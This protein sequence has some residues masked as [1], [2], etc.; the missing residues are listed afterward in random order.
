MAT[1]AEKV[2]D[3]NEDAAGGNPAA[4]EMRRSKNDDPASSVTPA[5]SPA[6]RV[7]AYGGHFPSVPRRFRD[8]LGDFFA[9]SYVDAGGRVLTSLSYADAADHTSSSPRRIQRAAICFVELGILELVSDQP[10]EDRAHPRDPRGRFTKGHRAGSSTGKAHTYQIKIFVDDEVSVKRGRRIERAWSWELRGA[11]RRAR[12]VFAGLQ[13]FNLPK[14][15]AKYGHVITPDG[16]LEGW[17]WPSID[18]AHPRQR[19][20][21]ALP[22]RIGR[23]RSYCYEGIAEL[24]QRGVV[25]VAMF[26]VNGRRVRGWKMPSTSERRPL[27]RSPGLAKS[28]SNHGQTRTEPMDKGG[29]EVGGESS[30]NDSPP[31]DSP[32]TASN[33]DPASATPQAGAAGAGGPKSA[34]P[35]CAGARAGVVPPDVLEV[36][37]V[38]CALAGSIV[39]A[40]QLGHDRKT[41]TTVAAALRAVATAVPGDA[42]KKITAALRA[43]SRHPHFRNHFDVAYLLGRGLSRIDELLR[44]AAKLETEKIS[45]KSPTPAGVKPDKSPPASSSSSA[46]PSSRAPFVPFTLAV[47]RPNLE[48]RHAGSC[49]PP[50]SRSRP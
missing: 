18:G 26:S 50:K 44:F 42:V 27:I 33:G 32:P 30:L 5:S 29:H 16:E 45:P 48:R 19:G 37:R 9:A 21:G 34:S 11:S 24:V 40:E 7:H 36:L 17:V 6:K 31:R 3:A 25:R 23:G 14:D 22:T 12:E 49:G 2:A 1:T 15:P 41:A 20:R 43:A 4:S 39:T 13:W 10:R 8:V 38:F 46:P 47:P 35:T 28:G